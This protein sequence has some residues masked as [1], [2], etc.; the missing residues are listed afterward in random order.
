MK[1]V[2]IKDEQN[3]SD[4]KDLERGQ[5]TLKSTMKSSAN[6]KFSST[7]TQ[8]ENVNYANTMKTSTFQKAQNRD[9][10]VDSEDEALNE[11]R[12]LT[13]IGTPSKA[14]SKN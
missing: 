12:V 14:K 5:H 11:E 2:I 8:D 1:E 6:T 3:W 13:K 4:L 7:K 10:D 9:F